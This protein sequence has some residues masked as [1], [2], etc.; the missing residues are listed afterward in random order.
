[1]KWA[2]WGYERKFV[3]NLWLSSS[4]TLGSSI[5]EALFVSVVMRF[6]EISDGQIS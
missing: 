6:N 2:H 3:L 5:T 1:M 4:M